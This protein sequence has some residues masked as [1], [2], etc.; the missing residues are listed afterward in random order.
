VVTGLVPERGFVASNVEPIAQVQASLLGLEKDVAEIKTTTQQTSNQVQAIATA[1]AAGFAQIQ[2]AFAALQANGSIVADPK[3]PQEWYSNARTYQLKGDTA[4]AIK[5]YEGFFAYQLVFVDP[6]QAYADLLKA[7]E[8]VARARQRLSDLQQAQPKNMAVELIAI[9]L[10]ESTQERLSQLQ[11][12]TSRQPEFAPAFLALAQEYDRALQASF[13]TDLLEK[14]KSAYTNLFALEKSQTFSRYFIDKALAQAQLAMA[15]ERLQAYDRARLVMGKVEIQHALYPD[16]VRF[17][18]VSADAAFAQKM[19]VSVDDPAPK[20]ESGKNAGGT[21]NIAVGPF[22]VGLGQHTFYAQII[23][24]NDVASP[25]YSHTFSVAPITVN[26][27]Q[28]PK[29][30]STNSIPGLFSVGILGGTGAE[31]VV[32]RWS[33]NNAN[34]GETLNGVSLMAIPVKDLKPGANTLHIQAEFPDGKK[35]DVVAFEFAVAE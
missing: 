2:G 13:S 26:F 16:G 32:Y 20:T 15:Q 11:A 27:V 12:F 6:H 19:L 7:T 1:Q 23:D 4:N 8:G 5:A 35:T 24:A 18:V 28:Q 9:G 10:Q 34:L 33:L 21:V 22:K 17:T 3:T 29:D 31:P 14:Q 25:V 30:F